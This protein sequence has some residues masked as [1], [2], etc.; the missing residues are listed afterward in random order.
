MPTHGCA[1]PENENFTEPFSFAK[2]QGS[3]LALEGISTEIGGDA[4]VKSPEAFSSLN[5]DVESP[6]ASSW[7][8]MF[9]GGVEIA[10][11]MAK[12]K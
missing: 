7:A 11:S 5:E 2:L 8:H 1:T 9:E 3:L 6:A 10:K 4:S 12:H